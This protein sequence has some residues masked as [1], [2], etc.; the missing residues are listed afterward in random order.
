MLMALMRTRPGEKPCGGGSERA[1]NA[2]WAAK[3]VDERLQSE[4]HFEQANHNFASDIKA[5]PSIEPPG[6]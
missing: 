5:K 2:A 4:S 3:F 6:S 1:G